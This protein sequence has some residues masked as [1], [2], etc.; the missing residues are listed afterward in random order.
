MFRSLKLGSAFGIGIY[1]HWTF[2]LLL[3]L[4]AF[5]SRGP[6]YLPALFSV[7]L[8][9]LVFA[10]IILHELGHALMARY[11][12]I[13]TR[14]ITIFPIGGVARLEKM[15]EKPLEEFLIAVAG[16]AVNVVIALGLGLLL[17]TAYFVTQGTLVGP[18]EVLANFGKPAELRQVVGAFGFV[19]V[20]LTVLMVANLF[21]VVF[22]MLPAFPMDGGRVLRA[23]L[24]A[25]IGYVP[26][27]ELAAALGVL[28]A[29]GMGYL[30][31]VRFAEQPLLVVVSMFVLMAGQ[32]E[33]AAV[34]SRAALRKAPPINVLPTD[35][36]G[37]RVLAGPPDPA[38]SGFTWNR[39]VGVWIEW[40][41]GR[42]VSACYLDKG[43]D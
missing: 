34:R 18:L 11:F 2:P 16:P 42:P 4:T 14:D 40:R 37:M 1:V 3:L 25:V 13:Q 33:L 10:C 20:I 41:D 19:P 30:G 38:Y 32:Q 29:F 35:G 12:G 15:S 9:V 8:V 6:D 31:I 28:L 24:S 7:S 26:A 39:D 27:T 21:L 43:D 36:G 17:T 23:L 22:N 5:L